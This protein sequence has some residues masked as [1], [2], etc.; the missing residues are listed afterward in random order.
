MTGELAP[1]RPG[2][3][4]VEVHDAVLAGG[5]EE[6]SVGADGDRLDALIQLVGDL[7]VVT[8]R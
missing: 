6:P 5:G 8:A 3:R 2:R 1:R 7:P 4:V